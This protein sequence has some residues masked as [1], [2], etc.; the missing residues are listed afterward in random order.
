[1][2]KLGNRQW[3]DNMS[4]NLTDP[5]FRV[6][7]FRFYSISR[8]APHNQRARFWQVKLITRR[9]HGNYSGRNR[10]ASEVLFTGQ[11]RSITNQFRT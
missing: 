11:E 3:P 4:N 2:L 1:M 5:L 7:F 8:N 10:G 6:V 9:L